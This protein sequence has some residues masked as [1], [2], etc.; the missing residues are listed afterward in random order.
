MRQ[1]EEEFGVDIVPT[2]TRHIRD[3]LNKRD[4]AIDK[5]ARWFEKCRANKWIIRVMIIITVFILVLAFGSLILPS[6]S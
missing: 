2:S 5:P 3:Y 4:E 1:V 6:P